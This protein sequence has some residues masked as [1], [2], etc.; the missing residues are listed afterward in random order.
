MF[1]IC[2]IGEIRHIA[3][4]KLLGHSSIAENS[5]SPLFYRLGRDFFF[6]LTDT[7]IEGR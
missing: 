7:L 6:F 4:L 5:Q 3:T 2:L 1:I